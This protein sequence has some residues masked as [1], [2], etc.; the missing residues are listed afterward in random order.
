[1]NN[2]TYD[3]L[4]RFTYGKYYGQVEL[5]TRIP[6]GIGVFES[7]EI[8]DNKIIKYIGMRKNGFRHG[9]GK[10]NFLDSIF[11]EGNWKNGMMDGFGALTYPDGSIFMGN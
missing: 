2:E 5:E 3:E 7:E 11:Y 4:E 10:I 1:M 6:F 9:L 8:F